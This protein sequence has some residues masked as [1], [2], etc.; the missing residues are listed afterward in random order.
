MRIPAAALIAACVAALTA[1]SGELTTLGGTGARIGVA[2]CVALI[3]FL[4]TVARWRDPPA[5]P[6]QR[7]GN[8]G[9]SSD[10]D[11]SL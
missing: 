8:G 11:G 10:G 5:L 3:A 2:A 9:S 7:D 1:L 4:G 6:P